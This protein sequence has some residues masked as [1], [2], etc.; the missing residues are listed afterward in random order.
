M[1]EIKVV[2]AD[3]SI[4]ASQVGVFVS[5][6]RYSIV[7]RVWVNVQLTDCWKMHRKTDGR[8][9]ISLR[10]RK[11]H[12]RMAGRLIALAIRPM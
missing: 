12:F 3:Y 9:D 5:L 11:F 7:F 4:D 8:T 6:Q 2:V 10:G 1:E